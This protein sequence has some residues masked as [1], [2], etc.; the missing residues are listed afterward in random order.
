MP[1]LTYETLRAGLRA[2]TTEEAASQ[3]LA[4]WLKKDV[5]LFD[6]CVESYHRDEVW[7]DQNARLCLAY[8]LLDQGRQNLL[9]PLLNDLKAAETRKTYACKGQSLLH[10]A[11]CANNP[12]AIKELLHLG[13][14]VEEDAHRKGSPLAWAVKLKKVDSTQALVA[15]GADWLGNTVIQGVLSQSKVNGKEETVFGGIQTFPWAMALTQPDVK[16]L[17]L[18]LESKT[19]PTPAQWKVG[20]MGRVDRLVEHGLETA[21]SDRYGYDKGW[22]KTLVDS[23]AYEQWW[24][25][26]ARKKLEDAVKAEP[27]RHACAYQALEKRLAG[28]SAEDELKHSQA[29]ML[30]EAPVAT[31]AKW[32]TAARAK[33]Y[34]AAE[35]KR[36][37]SAMRQEKDHPWVELALVRPS[38]AL[39]MKDALTLEKQALFWKALGAKLAASEVGAY[40][41][42]GALHKT[43]LD[44]LEKP[45]KEVFDM[46]ASEDESVV[47][48]QNRALWTAMTQDKAKTLFQWRAL[49]QWAVDTE[50]V[51]P[52]ELLSTLKKGVVEGS[53]W[54]ENKYEAWVH[55]LER[56]ALKK[57][58]LG[59]P[60][61][62]KSNPQHVVNSFAL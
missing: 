10:M 59:A 38:V 30:Q 42:S 6:E 31:L 1:K 2:S 53:W 54:Q 45:M 20:K 21:L 8:V 12:V 55:E 48:W 34:W 32:F 58:V 62:T 49:L 26:E 50:R 52:N 51:K 11:V 40:A 41:R 4:Q 15:S 46:H 7:A 27:A 35:E 43:R 18:A 17:K 23:G 57:S 14:P 60:R 61:A 9:W 24:S 16:I 36:V 3:K 5:G 33:E 28:K 22:W 19:K 47:A 29:L 44:S 25:E 39:L 13:W 56:S 37:T